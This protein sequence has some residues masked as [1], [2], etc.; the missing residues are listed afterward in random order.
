MRENT[1]ILK[2]KPTKIWEFREYPKGSL[3]ESGIVLNETAAFIYKLCDGD[4]KVNEIIEIILESYEVNSEKA[5]ID[6]INCIK[7]LL[8][9][10]AIKLK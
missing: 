2:A 8:N 10:D 6:T 5:K 7:E 1:N 9:A 4:K 3:L